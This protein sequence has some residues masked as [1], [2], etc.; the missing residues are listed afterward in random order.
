MN[1]IN[2]IC[3]IKKFLAP[4][5]SIEWRT[6]LFTKREE[7]ELSSP[8]QSLNDNELCK[9]APRVTPADR[10]QS[11]KRLRQN[12]WFGGFGRMKDFSR[13]SNSDRTTPEDSSERTTPAERTNPVDFLSSASERRFALHRIC[14]PLQIQ[15]FDKMEVSPC[16]HSAL[17]YFRENHRKLLTIIPAFVWFFNFHNPFRDGFYN[18][19]DLSSDSRI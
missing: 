6:S 3:Y 1:Y 8:L 15:W 5:S 7:Q 16:S 17:F 4:A 18:R 10:L 19:S 2:P 11:N 14:Y 12:E 9:P 13:T